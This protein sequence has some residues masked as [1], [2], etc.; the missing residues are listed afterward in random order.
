MRRMM[1]IVNSIY[2]EA[3]LFHLLS[4][5]CVTSPP[6]PLLQ[7]EG[8]RI[9]NSKSLKNLKLLIAPPSLAGKRAGGLG[10]WSRKQVYTITHPTKL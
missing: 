4:K 2:K 10:H 1:M 6:A 3:G 9:F 5:N 7:G 8:R